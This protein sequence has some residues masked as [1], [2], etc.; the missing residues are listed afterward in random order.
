MTRRIGMNLLRICFL[1]F[2]VLFL[3]S[4]T[5]VNEKYLKSDHFDG[6]L[7]FN[8]GVD[9]D[10][11]YSAL[12]KWQLTS[13]KKNWPDF[14][15]NTAKPQVATE[16]KEGEAFLT[17]INHATFLVQM[18]GMNILTDP[19]FSQRASPVQWAGP[20]RVHPPGLELDQLPKVDVVDCK[21]QSL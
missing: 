12:L 3:W 16:V 2:S 19:V 20:K 8:P 5:S 15:S 21:S 14:V 4:C 6:T 11:P 7:F 1:V 18:S 17:F 13:D 10:K 9:L